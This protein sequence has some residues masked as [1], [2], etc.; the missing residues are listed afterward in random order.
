[1]AID[2]KNQNFD[3]EKPKFGQF[4]TLKLKTFDLKH[5][6]QVVAQL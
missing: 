3:I 5:Q 2:L 6:N 1:M 4:L